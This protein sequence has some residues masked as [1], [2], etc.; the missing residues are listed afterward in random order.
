MRVLLLIAVLWA[1]AAAAEILPVPPI[2]PKDPPRGTSAPVP[3]VTSVA[4]VSAPAGVP[5]V[6]LKL[7]RANMFNTNLGFAP[8]SRFQDSE[9]RKPIQTPGLV[10]S[11]PFK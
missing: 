4:P 7:Y 11:V 3:D 9:E 8:G 6:T 5:S 10:V 1:T 2:P